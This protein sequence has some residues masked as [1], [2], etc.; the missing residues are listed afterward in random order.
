MNFDAATE[1]S[2]NPQNKRIALLLQG[3][4]ALGAYQAGVYHAMHEHKL[5][6]DWVARTSI[7]AINAALIAGNKKVNRIA[8]LKEFWDRVSLQDSVDIRNVPDEVRS[9]NSCLSTLDTIIRGIP[10]FFSPRFPSLFTA[11]IAVDPEAASFYDTRELAGTLADLVDFDYLNTERHMR[12]FQGV[13][14]VAV[15]TRVWRHDSGCRIVWMAP[16]SVW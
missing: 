16:R 2:L 5:I 7:G 6:P 15:G 4:G 1:N 10:R 12:I 11:G 3:G 8:R 14:S 13:D 9:M